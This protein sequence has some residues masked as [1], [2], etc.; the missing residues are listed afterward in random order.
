MTREEILNKLHGIKVGAQPTVITN[1]MGLQYEYVTSE[2]YGEGFGNMGAWPAFVLRRNPREKI[3]SIQKKIQAGVLCEEDLDG[4]ELR[5]FYDYV[6]GIWRPDSC[7]PAICELFSDLVSLSPNDSGEIYV[8]CDVC[9]WEPEAFF[10]LT[11]EEMEEAF[12]ELYASD[13]YQT[14]DELEDDELEAWLK[15]VD[16]ELSSIPLM[17]ITEELPDEKES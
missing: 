15:R 16:T 3:E 2:G 13:I 10:F 9:Q 1:D 12:E 17:S 5:P 7:V 14:W 11:Y 6:M 4:T 8:I